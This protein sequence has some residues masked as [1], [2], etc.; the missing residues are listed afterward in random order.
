VLYTFFASTKSA[1]FWGG[2]FGAY[3]E[4]APYTEVAPPV[5]LNPVAAP[6]PPLVEFKFKL[7]AVVVVPVGRGFDP[8]FP[9]RLRFKAGVVPVY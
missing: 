8:L 5:G 3:L 4:L 9:V 2:T 1:L 6:V 7:G